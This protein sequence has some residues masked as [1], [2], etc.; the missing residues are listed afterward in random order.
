MCHNFVLKRIQFSCSI[1]AGLV[2]HVVESGGMLQKRGK[3]NEEQARGKGKLKKGNKRENW[4]F[5]EVTVWD[6]IQL[7][8]CS[9]SYR[10]RK[11]GQDTAPCSKKMPDKA[12]IS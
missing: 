9:L 4:K 8:F 7:I 10:L 1:S 11:L 2:V 3:R 6:R 5:N 12:E